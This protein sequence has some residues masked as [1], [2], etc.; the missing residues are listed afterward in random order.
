MENNCYNCKFRVGVPGSVHSGCSLFP[1]ISHRLQLAAGVAAG[2]VSGI[3]L[4]VKGETKRVLSFEPTGV[5]NGW[6]NWPIDFDP[7]W[8]S[9]SIPME[10]AEEL[11][12]ALTE[13]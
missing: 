5:S 3:D 1:N 9:C 11:N 4:T 6:C 8:V 7:V 12:R 13:N 10:V 2:Q